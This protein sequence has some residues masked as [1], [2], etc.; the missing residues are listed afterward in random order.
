MQA[1]YS[2]LTVKVKV[3][4]SGFSK[5]TPFC[6]CMQGLHSNGLRWQDGDF[7]PCL[8][9]KLLEVDLSQLFGQLLQFL[10]SVLDGS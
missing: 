2:K 10:F 1:V 5:L 9:D 8:L 7:R 4:K 3:L 6:V